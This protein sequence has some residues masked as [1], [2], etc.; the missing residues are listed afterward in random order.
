MLLK[1]I[2]K[3]IGLDL[4]MESIQ[5]FK[6]FLQIIQKHMQNYEIYVR[7]M[8]YSSNA[9]KIFIDIGKFGV[10]NFN[11]IKIINVA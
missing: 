2:Y 1:I 10:P 3:I 11:K 9:Y 7:H 4:D 6:R 5:I 8:R